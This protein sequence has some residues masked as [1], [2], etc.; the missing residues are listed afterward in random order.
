MKRLRITKQTID[1]LRRQPELPVRMWY[2][3][4]MPVI[5][6]GSTNGESTL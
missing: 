3:V 4:A 2:P 1:R 6:E 5:F